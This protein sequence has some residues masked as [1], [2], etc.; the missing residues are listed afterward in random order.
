MKL[1]S[2]PEKFE[3]IF[4]PHG[5]RDFFEL[6][7]RLLDA[8][9]ALAIDLASDCGGK[10]TCGKCKVRID[11]G[12]ESLGKI[13]PSEEKHLTKD[14]IEGGYRLACLAKIRAPLKVYVPEISRVGKQRLQTEGLEV[15]V[16]AN[17]FVRKYFVKMPVPTLHDVRSDEDRLL[18]TLKK[19][20]KLDPNTLVMEFDIA[21]DF[22]KI[23][24]EANWEVTVTVWKDIGRY[25]I[26]TIEPGD[27]SGRCFGFACDI[28]STKLAG[29]LMDLNT[30]KVAAVGSRMNPQTPMGEDVLSRIT[31]VMMGGKEA[32]DKIHNLVV[33]GINEIIEECC[34]KAN[35]NINEIYELCFVGNTAMQMLFLRLWPQYTAF[36][37]YPP[38]LR[39][40]VNVPAPKLDLKSH[41]NANAYY[42]PVIGGF[43]GA[44]QIAVIQATRMLEREEI[45][46]DVDIGTNTEIALGNRDLVTSDS[47]ASGPAFEGMEIK[48]GIRAAT[49][50]IEAVSID[51]SSLELIHRTIEDQPPVGICGSAL[52]DIPAELLKSGLIDLKGKFVS[53]MAEETNRLR[54]GAEGW[55]YVIAWTDE[56]ATEHDIVITQGDIRELQ[57]AKA[58]MHTGAELML[59]MRGMTEKDIDKMWLAG[60]FGNY[61]NPENARTIGMYP[62]LPTEKYVFVGNA[63]GT[64]ARM[65]LISQEERAYVEKISTTVVYYELAT[66]PD[67]QSEYARA[68]YF[69]Y[70]D[71]N[72]YPLTRDLLLRLGRIDEKGKFIYPE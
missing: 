22:P 18:D 50:A 44:D 31:S 63:A 61:I 54:K 37:P 45:T 1:S 53:K 15:P 36:S 6:G 60:A 16:T 11:E 48:F 58:A 55:E 13:K 2:E 32:Q 10:G 35:V 62:E 25:K 52:I 43:V 57:K 29:F 40:G 7:T 41:P 28:G 26:I 47:C 4:L 3:V 38:V 23:A 19:Q 72:K 14:M 33:G 65:S 30:G 51:P 9:R 68:N 5:R 69:P 66:D 64:G 27:T 67:F 59:R 34:E 24:R 46:M 49:G 56:S 70:Q 20:Y 8:S 17:P 39:R 42:V 71:L 21:N 12:L